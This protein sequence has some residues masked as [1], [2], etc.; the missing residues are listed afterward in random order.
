MKTCTHCGR[1]GQ[2]GYCKTRIGD[3]WI[4]E[5]VDDK[6]CARRYALRH[7]RIARERR[8]ALCLGARLA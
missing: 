5:C 1:R 8:F 2:L 4:V 3:R 6:A 7:D